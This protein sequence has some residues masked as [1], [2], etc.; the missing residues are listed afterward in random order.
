MSRYT[1]SKRQ[2]SGF[3]QRLVE[4]GEAEM[5]PNIKTDAASHNTLIANEQK[6]SY[7]YTKK[8]ICSYRIPTYRLKTH[9]A[10]HIYIYAY[11]QYISPCFTLRYVY[12]IYIYTKCQY[13]GR[14]PYLTWSTPAPS[15]PQNNGRACAATSQAFWVTLHRG[16]LAPKR[17]CHQIGVEPKIGGKPPKMDGLFHGKP[18]LKWMIWGETPLFLVQHPNVGLRLGENN[19][20]T[21]KRPS[22]PFARSYQLKIPSTPSSHVSRRILRL[23]RRLPRADTKQPH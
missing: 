9:N 1:V 16:P 21:P 15:A 14:L 23:P 10:L 5:L 19:F 13:I 18:L 8:Y 22:L 17:P 2:K 4:I 20:L 3:R 12:I 7:T 11:V 6:E